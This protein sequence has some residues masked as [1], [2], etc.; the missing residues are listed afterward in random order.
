M[1]LLAVPLVLAAVLF[2]PSGAPVRSEFAAPA[3]AAAD[4]CTTAD[5]ALPCAM[6]VSTGY[7]CGAGSWWVCPLAVY[8]AAQCLT[9]NEGGGGPCEPCPYGGSTEPSAHDCQAAGGWVVGTNAC[10]GNGVCCE[11]PASR[12]TD[13]TAVPPAETP[14]Q[15]ALK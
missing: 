3:T 4:V 10:T 2:T 13:Q 11:W 15:S 7:Q 1:K 8:W 5:C 9:C 12:P 14:L 6:A